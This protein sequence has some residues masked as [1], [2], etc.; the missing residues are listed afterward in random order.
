MRIIFRNSK[1]KMDEFAPALTAIPFDE[2]TLTITIR[3]LP[4]ESL[5]YEFSLVASPYVLATYTTLKEAEQVLRD[6]VRMS[7][8]DP[9]GAYDFTGGK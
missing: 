1:L 6:I 8:E 2:A 7:K 3:R 4:G 9:N 5:E